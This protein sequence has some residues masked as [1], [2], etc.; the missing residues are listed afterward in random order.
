MTQLAGYDDF[1]SQNFGTTGW[2][3]VA[4]FGSEQSD[5]SYNLNSYFSRQY[6]PGTGSWLSQ[7]SYRGLLTQ[8]QSVNRYAFVTNNPAT[9]TDVLGYRPYNPQGITKSNPNAAFYT[10]QPWHPP[11]ITPSPGHSFG[12]SVG[13]SGGGGASNSTGGSAARSSRGGAGPGGDTK[14][15]QPRH[16]RGWQESLSALGTYAGVA[17]NG[18]AYSCVALKHLPSCYAGIGLQRFSSMSKTDEGKIILGWATGIAS[19]NTVYGP[20][21]GLVHN[22]QNQSETN[23]AREQILSALASTGQATSRQAN[24]VASGGSLIPNLARDSCTYV[25]WDTNCLGLGNQTKAALGSYELT[26]TASNV[27]EASHTATITYVGSNTTTLGSAIGLIPGTRDPLNDFARSTGFFSEV[28]QGFSW[29]E[30]V[31]W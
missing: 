20:G 25:L 28:D 29:T 7:D 30:E 1:G 23:T 15:L 12:G 8:P 16:V 13:T 9:L 31:T 3:A 27:N 2:N 21:S 5:P 17:A 6:D 18:L 24:Y 19:K 14:Y 22:L 4:G 26:A 11:M 10:P